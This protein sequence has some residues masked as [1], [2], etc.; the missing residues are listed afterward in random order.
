MPASRGDRVDEV[1][2]GLMN[3]IH[4]GTCQSDNRL[5]HQEAIAD[6]SRRV[7]SAERTDGSP[8]CFIERF[9]IELSVIDSGDAM[10][11][12]RGVVSADLRRIPSGGGVLS[13]VGVE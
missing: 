11:R 12:R 4:S 3:G 7:A 2:T 6:Y 1:V 13:S 5:P 8:F 9:S 10:S